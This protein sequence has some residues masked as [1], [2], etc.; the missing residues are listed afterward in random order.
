MYKYMSKEEQKEYDAAKEKLDKLVGRYK[1][2]EIR[3]DKFFRKAITIMEDG[4]I[5]S[6][7]D[8]NDASIELNESY[9]GMNNILSEAKRKAYWGE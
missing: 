2:G 8:E 6:W 7:Y 3:G 4:H 1:D 9:K 5:I